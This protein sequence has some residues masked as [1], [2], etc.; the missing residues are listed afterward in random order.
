MGTASGRSSLC[1]TRFRCFSWILY[2][3][4]EWFS[5]AARH[6][7]IR[8]PLYQSSAGHPHDRSRRRRG[9]EASSDI[10]GRQRFHLQ[11]VRSNPDQGTRGHARAAQTSQQLEQAHE[12][13]AKRSTLDP[14]TGLRNQRYLQDHST[15][16][17]WPSRAI[18]A[19]SWLCFASNWTRST[20]S[21]RAW[22]ANRR[23]AFSL[24]R[25]GN[26]RARSGDVVARVGLARFAVLMSGIDPTGAS[27]A[28]R[29]HGTYSGER[30]S[31]WGVSS[32]DSRP[33]LA[34][35]PGS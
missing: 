16:R 6:P 30:A 12:L 5:I 20:S 1:S 29:I 34:L 35:S 21:L 18:K 15:P 9:D 3:Q 26:H 7:R 11:A 2:T 28:Q 24:R 31:A 14:L 19:P 25:Q 10:L 13:L 8:A 32:A 33:A 23:K 22:A 4:Q 17:C 27:R